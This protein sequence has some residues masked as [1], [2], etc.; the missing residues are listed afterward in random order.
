[1]GD[2]PT[3][4]E[5]ELGAARLG[6]ARRTARL[7]DL[8]TT[9]GDA[10]DAPLPV[11]C[12]SSAR[13][14]AAY[15]FFHNDAIAPTALR[16]PHVR[17][18]VG[19]MAALP[20]VLAVQDTTELDY[21][22]H[23]A[24]TGLGPL[25]TARQQGLFVHTTLAVAPPTADTPAVPL[26][27]LDP[28]VWTRDPATFGQLPDHKTRAIPDKESSKWLHSLRA[29]T[30]VAR[31]CPSTTQVISVCDAEGDVYDLFIAPRPAQVHLLVRACRDRCVE[32]PQ[33]YLWA[34]LVAAPRATTIQVDLPRRAGRPARVAVL[35]VRYRAVTLRPPKHRPA[36][37][38]PAVPIWA[39]WAHE[40]HPPPGVEPVSWR[41]LT[42]W[43]VAS[44]A[45]ALTVIRWYTGRWCIEVWHRVLKTGCAIE[46]RRLQA[47]DDLVRCLS[48][49][50]ILAW[51]V[52]HATLLARA[53]PTVPCTVVLE[54]EEWQALYCTIHQTALPPAVPPTLGEALTWLARLGGYQPRAHGRPAGP[55]VVWRGFQRLGPATDMYRLLKPHLQ[56]IPP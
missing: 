36:E 19:R 38:L 30:Q 41:L 12:G 26:G 22:A 21:T 15:R 28:R 34:A 27:V 17:A 31:R 14:Q 52:L 45:D 32:D 11:A 54:P 44:T 2:E 48:L 39:V 1:M 51:R 13:L 16:A 37:H 33:Q 49:Y 46:D 3:W 18:T 23:P 6:D 47:A 7:V 9:L 25:S 10:L 43:P 4:A 50:S 53:V 5:R 24:A 29:V 20:V 56:S 42:T 8:A 55:V 40:A 35:T